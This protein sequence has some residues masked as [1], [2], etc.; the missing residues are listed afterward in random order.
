M[1]C[2]Y[3]DLY[4]KLHTEL[5]RLWNKHFS[6]DKFVIRKRKPTHPIDEDEPSNN[7]S[8]NSDLLIS[9]DVDYDAGLLSVE[10]SKPEKDFGTGS[11]QT[12]VQHENNVKRKCGRTFQE[13]WK[14]KFNWLIYENEKQRAF[15]STCKAARDENMP[16]PT[17]SKQM[18]SAKCFVEDGFGNWKKALEKFQSHEKSDFLRAAVLF[19][20]S[21]GKQSVSQLISNDHAKQMKDNRVALVKIFTS[22]RYLG[23]QGLPVRG[24]VEEQSNLITLLEERADDV[25]ELQKWLK[26]KEKFK[27]LSPEVTNEI[28]KTFSYAIL[29]QLKDEVMT[30]NAG[31]YGI[32]LD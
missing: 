9:S 25:V 7:D 32:I 22:L 12:T 19:T 27:W 3:T 15:C 16:L 17:S 10:V 2:A 14:Q 4:M 6:M 1:K 13:S 24:E 28:L 11:S 26:R 29:Q 21:K 5:G 30:I 8:E 20:S 18:S 23:R 31:Y